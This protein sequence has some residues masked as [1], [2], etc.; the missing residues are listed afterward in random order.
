MVFTLAA[1]V[2]PSQLTEVLGRLSPEVSASAI[3]QDAGRAPLTVRGR[4]SVSERVLGRHYTVT[5]EGF[6]QIH[7]RAPET[8]VGA[9]L[10]ALDGALPAGGQVADLYAG[11]GLF[12]VGSA[13]CALSPSLEILTAA[14]FVQGLG[15]AAGMA[16]GVALLRFIVPKE[17]LGAAIGWNALAVALSSAAGPTLGAAILSL[18]SWP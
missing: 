5:G 11:A 10:E 1:G 14:R 13:L 12:T 8:L 17:R 18:G 6:W 4:G 2:G 7:R 16:L 15:G 9:A 3:G